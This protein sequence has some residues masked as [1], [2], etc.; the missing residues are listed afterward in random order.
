MRQAGGGGGGICAG[1]KYPLTPNGN[2]GMGGGGCA[3]DWLR[4][5]GV[6]FA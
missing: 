6:A 2:G 4:Q 5:V 1:A 3:F